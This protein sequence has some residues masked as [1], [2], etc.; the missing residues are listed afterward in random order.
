MERLTRV[1]TIM[2]AGPGLAIQAQWINHPIAGVPRLPIGQANLGAPAPRTADGKPDLSGLWNR[3]SP[4]YRVNITADLKPEE[5]QPWAKALT[6]QRTENLGRDSMNAL[7]L[8][9]GPAYT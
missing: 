7:C 1:L 3:I 8:P 5:V 4:R 2:I 9:S 6:Q